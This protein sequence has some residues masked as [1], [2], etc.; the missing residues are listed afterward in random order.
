MTRKEIETICEVADILLSLVKIQGAYPSPEQD[1]F[2]KLAKRCMDI[3]DNE[4]KRI[5]ECKP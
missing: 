1:K 4:K 5:E 3:L 2:V